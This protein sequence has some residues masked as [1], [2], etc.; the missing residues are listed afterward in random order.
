MAENPMKF[1]YSTCTTWLGE[2]ATEL[3]AQGFKVEV[4]EN[5]APIQSFLLKIANSKIE[6]EL[7]VWETGATSMIVVN[8]STSDYDLDRSDILLANDQFQHGLELF[9]ALVK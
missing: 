9:F 6:A 7:V 4:K 3:T 1:E 5:A 2:R 8:L